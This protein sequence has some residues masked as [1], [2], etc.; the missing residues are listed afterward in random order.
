MY[1]AVHNNDLEDLE[2]DS[3]NNMPQEPRKILPGFLYTGTKQ[4]RS[5]IFIESIATFDK[6]FCV[7]ESILIWHSISMTV[8]AIQK[9]QPQPSNDLNENYEMSLYEF[10]YDI[11]VQ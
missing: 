8:K 11:S 9:S 1:S 10:L 3:S 6:G 5:L 4:V 7:L 2:G